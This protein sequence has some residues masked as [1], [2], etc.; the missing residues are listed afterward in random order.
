[1]KK[2]L[3]I[4]FFSVTTALAIPILISC[5]NQF[6]YNKR[7]SSLQQ[8]ELKRI[9]WMIWNEEPEEQI[10]EAWEMFVVREKKHRPD[11]EKTMIN[12]FETVKII[13]TKNIEFAQEKI[14]QAES[15]KLE[16]NQEME[17]IHN[18]RIKYEKTKKFTPFKLKKIESIKDFSSRK[19]PFKDERISSIKELDEYESYIQLE[20]MEAQLQG[21]GGVAL[22]EYAKDAIETAASNISGV[23]S[24]AIK[25]KKI[26]ER[27]IS[28]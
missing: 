15:V 17:N 28:A 4:T 21:T 7:L 6:N 25:M 13:A 9:A 27:K 2:K 26:V 24:T 1:M 11:Y 14:R 16:V 22:L 8:E 10:L 23:G 20:G 18:L 12:I 3:F 5:Q 19:N